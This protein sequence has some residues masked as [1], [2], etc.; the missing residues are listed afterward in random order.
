MDWRLIHGWL[1]EAEGETLAALGAGLHVVELGVWKGRSTAAV[2]RSAA[3]VTAVDG[4]IGDADTGPADTIA[5]FLANTKHCENV[6]CLVARFEDGIPM[7]A[8]GTAD[9]VFIDGQHDEASAYRDSLIARRILKPGGKVA[10]HDF[11]YPTVQAAAERA[12]FRKAGQVDSL[13]WGV[14]A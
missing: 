13:A 11:T 7:I 6:Y 5:A 4:F 1:T 12:A 10:Y 2:A 14:F 3:T 8:D 9:L